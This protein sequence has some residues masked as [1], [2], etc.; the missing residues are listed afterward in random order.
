MTDPIFFQAPQPV[1]LATIAEW[2]GAELVRGDA[3]T[4]IRGVAPVED[5]G[6]GTLVFFDNMVYADRLQTTKAAAC[7]VSKK[8]QGKVPDGVAVLVCPDAYRSWAEVLAKLYPDAM[9]PADQGEARISE[10]ATVDPNARLEEGV[11]VSPG[12]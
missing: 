12:P 10:K 1:D 4:P 8:H 3:S 7:L 5:A 11:R 2:A 6:E 9:T